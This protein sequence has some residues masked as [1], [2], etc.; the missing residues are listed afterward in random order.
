VQQVS[1]SVLMVDVADF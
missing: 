1:G